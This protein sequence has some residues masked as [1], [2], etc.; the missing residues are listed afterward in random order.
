MVV[1]E[2][3]SAMRTASVRRKLCGLANV[4]I[5]HDLICAR[6]ALP[7]RVGTLTSGHACR[8][9]AVWAAKIPTMT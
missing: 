1:I 4:L 2:N 6:G 8:R 3:E 5:G 7:L 9:R